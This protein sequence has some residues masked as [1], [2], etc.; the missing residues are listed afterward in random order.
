MF[1]TTVIHTMAPKE[2][3]HDVFGDG[4]GNIDVEG[5]IVA[6]CLM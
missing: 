3:S 6:P 4:N 2:V 1:V 5:L